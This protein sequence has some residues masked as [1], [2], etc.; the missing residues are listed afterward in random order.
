MIIYVYINIY[1]PNKPK[2]AYLWYGVSKL[3]PT[4]V[5]YILDSVTERTYM[6]L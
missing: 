2:Y 1:I 5:E 6:D 3:I 4:L